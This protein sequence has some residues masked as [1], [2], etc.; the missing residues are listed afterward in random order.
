MPLDFPL[1]GARTAIW[2]GAELHLFFV[3]FVVGGAMFL[4]VVSEW[5]GLRTGDQRYERLAQETMKVVAIAYSLTAIFGVLFAF[6]LMGPYQPITNYLFRALYPV[7]IAYGAFILLET[8]CMYVYWYTWEPLSRTATGKW[9]HIGIGVLLNV[10]GTAVMLLM[11]AV[12]GF[13]NTP[14]K[15]IETATLWTMVNNASWWPLN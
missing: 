6:V 2:L 15:A 7:W 9:T 13:M 5:L 4:M 11:K 1:I 14:P 12:T 10:L 8:V 3:A